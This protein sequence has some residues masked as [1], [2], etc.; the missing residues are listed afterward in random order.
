MVAQLMDLR[1]SSQDGGR[2]LGCGKGSVI[3]WLISVERG[4]SQLRKHVL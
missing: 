4:D 1:M 3:V 2:G